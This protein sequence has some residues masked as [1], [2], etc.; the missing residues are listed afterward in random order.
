MGGVHEQVALLIQRLDCGD[1]SSDN[2][3]SKA[4]FIFDK[5]QFC[6]THSLVEP[7]SWVGLIHLSKA[8]IAFASHARARTV[9][10]SE[11]PIVPLGILRAQHFVF[12]YGKKTRSSSRG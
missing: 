4:A 2:S 11:Q 8:I 12:A 1:R 5:Y 3:T 7:H 6:T 9:A 10:A